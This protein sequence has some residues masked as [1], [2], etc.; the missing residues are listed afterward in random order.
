MVEWWDGDR[1]GYFGRNDVGLFY[2]SG[3]SLEGCIS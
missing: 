2:K 1:S 3:V